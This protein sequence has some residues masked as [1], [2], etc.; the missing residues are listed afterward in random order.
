MRVPF[1]KLFFAMAL[2]I[3]LLAGSLVADA[4]PTVVNPCQIPAGFYRT[5][6]QGAWGGTCNGNN[7]ACALD[8]NFN[9]VFPTHLV[10]GGTHTITFLT[11][12]DVEA[13]LP[14][15]GSFNALAMDYTNPTNSHLAG[16]FAGQVIALAINV[17]FSNANVSGF[18][19]GLGSLYIPHGVDTPSGPF[20][21]WTVAQVLAL[22]NAVLGGSTAL[23]SGISISELE[24]VMDNINGSFEDG[25]HSTYYLVRWDCDDI[26]AAE[27]ASFDAVGTTGAIVVSWR[28]A[29]ERSVSYFELSRSDGS[30]QWIPV[31]SVNSR[32]DNPSG[33]VY[34]YTDVA[35]R[36]GIL[37]SYRLTI[38][39]ANGDNPTYG[40]MVSAIAGPSAAALS[41]TL[42]QNYPNPFNPTTTITYTLAQSVPV[43]LT[44]YDL[45]GRAVATLV[46][47]TQSAGSHSV[48]FNGS[49]LPSAEYLCRLEAGSYTAVSKMM[50][51]K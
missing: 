23:P 37:Y 50:L 7:S 45:T 13:F 40:Q 14:A 47:K 6:T 33:N 44:V 10:V 24:T 9:A 27:M 8:N 17:A 32:G 21:G 19:V 31:A 51:I 3:V 39:N 48:Q 42:A 49:N 34:S 41:F 15:G 35:V 18:P 38:H 16:S 2:A 20:A 46:E 25:L 26:L 12:A 11:A 36:S 1:Y 28:T 29:S 5:Q 22:G 30:G 43:K 4:Q